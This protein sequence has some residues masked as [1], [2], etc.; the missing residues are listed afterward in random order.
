M[1]FPLQFLQHPLPI[2]TTPPPPSASH[3]SAR[4]PPPPPPSCSSAL[5]P[6]RYIRMLQSTCQHASQHWGA[7]TT[8]HDLTLSQRLQLA[9]CCNAELQHL[10]IGLRHHDG[11]R[12]TPLQLAAR[13][14]KLTGGSDGGAGCGHYNAVQTCRQPTRANRNATIRIT[15]HATGSGA[16]VVRPL[17]RSLLHPRTCATHAAVAGSVRHETRAVGQASHTKVW[18]RVQGSAF[19]HHAWYNTIGTTPQAQHHRHHCVT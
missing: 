5:S 15:R 16:C 13:L 18:S 17:H 7:S 4:L 12:A 11:A 9:H 3:T 2:L 1:P 6:R 19:T 8:R 10:P 14:H